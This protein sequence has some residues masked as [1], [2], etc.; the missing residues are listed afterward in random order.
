[1]VAL[2]VDFDVYK[3]LTNLRATEEVTYNDVLRRLLDI[4]NAPTKTVQQST[5]G[6]S[7]KGLTLPNG[8]EL[9]ATHKGKVRTAKIENDSWEQE[10]QVY[11]SPT[12]A[13]FAITNYGINGWWF[14]QVKR[15]SDPT[16][17][18]LGS[19]RPK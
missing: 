14:W 2:D 9:R 1:M 3:A 19:L 10:G 18:Q 12:A 8:T 17:V 5:K 13:A 15:P 4:K 7:W 16:W 6:W 11:T